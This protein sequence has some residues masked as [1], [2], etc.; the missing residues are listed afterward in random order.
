MKGVLKLSEAEKLTLEQLSLNHRH[1]D[2]E[3]SRHPDPSGRAGTAGPRMDRARGG[4]PTRRERAVALAH[5]SYALTFV[6]FGG[7]C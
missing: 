5:R 4:G 3:T 2:I 6:E 7:N 1:R